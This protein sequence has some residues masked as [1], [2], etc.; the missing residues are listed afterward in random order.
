MG[1]ALELA[2]ALEVEYLAIVAGP[3]GLDSAWCS[4]AGSMSV[5]MSMS[6]SIAGPI[7]AAGVTAVTVAAAPAPVAAAAVV[8]S[9]RRG[10]AVFS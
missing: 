1:L 4:M 6:M 3:G 7:G 5:S 9:S 2:L 8:V 10:A